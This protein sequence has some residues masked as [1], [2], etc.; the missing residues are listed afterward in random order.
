M[1]KYLLLFTCLLAIT[2][3]WSQPTITSFTPISGPVGTSITITGTNFSATPANNIVYFGGVRATTISAAST[4]QLTVVVPPGAMHQPIS[5]TVAGLK[6][7]S[8]KPFVVAFGG[9][10]ISTSSFAAR[11]SFTTGADPAYVALGDLDGDGKIDV[12]TPN[13]ASIT[14]ASYFRNQSTGPGSIAYSAKTDF[15]IGSNPISA[16]IGDIDGDGLP[17]VVVANYGTNNYSIFRNTSTVGTISFAARVNVTA[18]ASST[19]PYDVKIQDMDGDG[20]ADLIVA[21]N[22]G[23]YLSVHR[24]TGSVG[25]I[26][27]ATPIDFQ[28]YTS[29]VSVSIGD[30]DGDGKPDVA[31]ANFFNTFDNAI[32]VFRNTST[33][34]TI[35]FATKLDLTPGSQP[36]SVAI[37]DIDGDGK[38][39][40]AVANGNSNNMSIFR[41]T[42][43]VG[44]LS[45]AARVDVT[46]GTG[47]FS[48]SLGDI[49]GDSKVDL[50][51]ANYTAGTVS[52][53]RNNSTPGTISIA[54][55]VDFTSTTQPRSVFIADQDGDGKNDLTTANLGSDN[56]SVF[57]NIIPSPQTIT[58]GP[59]AT[60]TIGDFSF[61]VSATASSGLPVTFSSDNLAVAAVAGNTVEIIGAGTCNIIAS[62]A[63]NASFAPAPN[64][65]QPLVVNK[66]NQTITFGAIPSKVFSDPAFTL[67]GTSSSGLP[68][69]YTSSNTSVATISGNTV[70][71]TGVG[72]T[73][74]TAS[75]P[76]NT[77]YNPAT[78]VARNLTVNKATQTITF[79]ALP[80]KAFGD[81]NFALGATAS[82]GLPIS[83]ISSNTS[84]ATISGLTVTI[85]GVGST[86]ITASQA[87]DANYIAANSV[88]QT[89]TVNKANQTIS[90]GSLPSKTFG[91]AAFSLTATT[92]S[93][94]P[95]TYT[96][97]NTAVATISGN[98]VT[99]LGTGTSTIT[100]SQAG[101]ANY[102]AA[103]SVGQTLTVT[104]ADQ[105]IVFNS[106]P[107]KVFGDAPFSLS[108][109]ASSNLPITFNSNNSAV[110]TISGNTVT[111]IGVGTATIT[112]S[113]GGS[114]NYNAAP[115]V[116]QTLTVSKANQ[117]ITFGSLPTKTFGDGP[118]TIS[119]SSSSGLPVTFSSSNTA[120]ATVSGNTI[121]ILG[122]GNVGIL[123]SQAGN[124]NYNAATV[125]QQFL[126]I[127]KAAQTI[128]FAPLP[129]KTVGDPS[130]TISA[131]S[132]SGLPVTFS[133]NNASVA[134]IS[135]TT[136][137]INGGGTVT[138]TAN[139][140]GNGNYLPA[141]SA[142][143]QLTVN[144]LNQ[145][146]TF[147]PLSTRIVGDIF[148]LT[149]SSSSSLG[150]T[151]S[152]SNT[153]VATI[154]GTSLT[155]VGAGTAV[156]T[157]SQA[158]N[159]S[160]NP[161]TDVQQ[162]LTANKGNQVITFTSLPDKTVGDPAFN[163]QATASSGLSVTYT[164]TS[165]RISISGNQVT[166]LSGGRTNVTASQAGNA[167]YNAA[168]SVTQSFCI[169][170]AKPTIAISNPN[171][172]SPTLTSSAGDGNQWFK[173]GSP[174]SGATNK[175]LT[176]TSE[177]VYKV[178]STIDDC[179]SEF[180]DAI[181][182]VVTG[183]QIDPASSIAL[184]PNPASEEL[185]ISLGGFD[186][187]LPVEVK[188]MDI[189]GRK[190]QSDEALGGAEVKMNIRLLS[191]GQYI[192]L[193][194]QGKTRVAKSFI[195]ST[196]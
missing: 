117:T 141:T 166:I 89:L 172:A 102:N 50:A 96:S 155:V 159:A 125:V 62:Q 78:D 189:Y 180:S 95:I 97:S 49:D 124:A 76:G 105:T 157:A 4:T 92:S 90:F 115:N 174:I 150:V 17:D 179:V 63:G 137:T 178:Q 170:P 38:S 188:L 139:Q 69:T 106:L 47:P 46:T 64:V 108:A 149:A 148:T 28:A 138:I 37:G 39:D 111:I 133:G 8:A 161:A 120:I 24:N 101:N 72:S 132:S 173:D 67:S 21:N 6:A 60:K 73:T 85:V 16:F 112:A 75:Q 35:N 100:A 86:I 5:V 143:Q 36:R 71:I 22:G 3:A 48:V 88:Q 84:V 158:G 42:S 31:L 94:L 68:I 61:T 154:S 40:L 171:T 57:R 177:G 135:G 116:Q 126:T 184:Y 54:T 123:A 79:G 160:Y 186:S 77:S 81:A 25:T 129:T 30:L 99:I 23:P 164:T 194:Q 191:Q 183:D 153:S 58:F 131:T 55:K 15:T 167:N 91:S 136:V 87:G 65:S 119:A 70:T 168:S 109:T 74:I 51:V 190:L 43:S 113:Q 83:Y 182:I 151:Y 19:N 41:N 82:S 128:S 59:L 20:K 152:S 80:T 45:F 187:N 147:N 66:A 26:S 156:I 175:T 9:S 144:K 18:S 104:P 162:T 121:T 27:F 10:G 127:D 44:T 53:F 107:A 122:A 103:I 140:A 163:L 196:N 165:P 176:L 12:V 146:I 110:A 145:T 98:T 93:G 34:G 13:N 11:Q 29:P 32:S 134:T 192:V 169:K 142:S 118:F 33:P 2:I 130:F 56:F 1:K 193:M 195:K 7:Y 114:S 52:V 14:N 185:I 181:T